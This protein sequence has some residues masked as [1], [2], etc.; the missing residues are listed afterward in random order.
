MALGLPSDSGNSRAYQ[1][2]LCSRDFGEEVVLGRIHLMFEARCS[3]RILWYLRNMPVIGPTGALRR[4]KYRD[5]KL[6]VSPKS[7]GD[8]RKRLDP[9]GA[10]FP[11]PDFPHDIPKS[12]IKRVPIKPSLR[13]LQ[14]PSD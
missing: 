10:V 5:T 3:S 4:G 13:V 2:N 11:A 9:R 14:G 7:T 8:S 12:P 1:L 6:G